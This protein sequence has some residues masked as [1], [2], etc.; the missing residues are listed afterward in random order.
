[1]EHGRP[2]EHL[3]N[4]RSTTRHGRG[5]RSGRQARVQLR[6]N[7]VERRGPVVHVP[8]KTLYGDVHPTCERR[9]A[10]AAR[11]SDDTSMAQVLFFGRPADPVPPRELKLDDTERLVA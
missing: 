1:M 10:L 7:V 9:A 11:L 5:G 6:H 2:T 4:R 3:P 8:F